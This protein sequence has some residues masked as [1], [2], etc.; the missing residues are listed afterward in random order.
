MTFLAGIY[1]QQCKSTHDLDSVV[2]GHMAI[3][4][5]LLVQDHSKNQRLLLKALPGSSN[6][7]KLRSLIEHAEDF[8]SFYVDFAKRVAES[9]SQSQGYEDEEDNDDRGDEESHIG[10]P[11]RDTKGEAVA[12]NAIAFLEELQRCTYD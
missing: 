2:R 10:K 1:A 12:R 11:V 5:G 6:R 4:F 9:Q 7:N 3:L 8:T